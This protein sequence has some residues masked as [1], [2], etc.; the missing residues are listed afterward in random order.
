MNVFDPGATW[1]YELQE[2]ELDFG[3]APDSYATLAESGGA[4]HVIDSDL[5][6]GAS[7]PD[8][9]TDGFSDG[10]EDSP[11][12]ATDDDT[13]G[14]TPDD[15]DGV[16]SF[17]TLRTTDTTYSVDVTATNNTGSGATLIGWIDF[18]CD[19]SFQADEGT[20]VSVA[21]GTTNSSATL[22][23]SNIG[24]TGPNITSGD[25]F[26]RFRLTTDIDITTSTPGGETLD[27]EVE[28]YSVSIS[29]QAPTDIILSNSSVAE[30]QTIG[31][32]VGTFSTIDPDSGD[33]HTYSLVIGAGDTD[34]SS[35]LIVGNE[36]QTNAVFDHETQSTYSV[37]IRATDAGSLSYEE[38]FT[39]SVVDVSGTWTIGPSAWSAAGLALIRDGNVLHVHETG[40][41]NDA[42]T[43]R[44]VEDATGI[45]ITGRD[46][47][48]DTLTVDFS[49]GDPVPTGGVS[50]E[51]GTGGHD[52]LALTGGSFTT[53]T[54][55]FTNANAGS[56][57]LDG[58][59][60]TY[61][62]LEPIRSTINA[63]NVTLNYSNT[64]ETITVTASDSQTQVSSTAGEMVTF[65][66]P[67][68]SLI[69]S[70][71]DGDDTINM[72][73]LGSESVGLL[74]VTVSPA[75]ELT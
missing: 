42:V 11:N 13:K 14:T 27:G 8:A 72:E 49:D 69:I 6:M 60:I 59:V 65:N 39:I 4:R 43:P 73:G 9:D 32:P 51:G 1:Q 29:N 62:G 68:D 19:G 58:S 25:T 26:A 67:I 74:N 40:T 35:F 5:F 50:Y 52:T 28:D 53:T 34:N 30:N 31:T 24:T 66:N 33:T 16:V 44:G 56:I 37:R 61:T 18:D 47:E 12:T 2:G 10:T 22:T 57:D 55:N 64:A 21:D 38:A 36:L 48:Y 70:A 45:A 3:D 23:W 54:Y 41:T 7:A 46:S 17:D 20:M 71:G 75:V 63:T 15:E